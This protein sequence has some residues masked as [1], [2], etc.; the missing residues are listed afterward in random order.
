MELSFQRVVFRV[1][2][3]VG[4]IAPLLFDG[5]FQSLGELHR[6]ELLGWD[7]IFESSIFLGFIEL[8]I[9]AL[10]GAGLMHT[11]LAVTFSTRGWTTEIPVLG[12]PLARLV[13][14]GLVGFFENP[15]W[16][17]VLFVRWNFVELLSLAAPLLRVIFSFLAI[18]SCAFHGLNF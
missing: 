14:I 15:L 3:D 18:F 12:V 16:F 13:K 4:A 17:L 9:F 1:G 6:L 10:A 2:V 8:V 11:V 5:S 7:F